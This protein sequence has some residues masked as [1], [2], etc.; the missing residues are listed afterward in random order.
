[1]AIVRPDAAFLKTAGD[2]SDQYHKRITVT[3]YP[4]LL[5]RTKEC[6]ERNSRGVALCQLAPLSR[7]H[8]ASD[9]GR[10]VVRLCLA[11]CLSNGIGPAEQTN[12]S[13]TDR[14]CR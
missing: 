6:K 2:L 9:T 3:G 11:R 4:E 14:F 13:I 1:M 12:D 10:Q 8:A 5:T 7:V